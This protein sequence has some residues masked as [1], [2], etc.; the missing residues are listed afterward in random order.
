MR[1][2]EEIVFMEGDEQDKVGCAYV[3]ICDIRR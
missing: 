2:L 1:G 3:E